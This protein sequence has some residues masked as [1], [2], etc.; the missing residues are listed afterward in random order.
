M[1]MRAVML[2]AAFVAD[3]PGAPRASAQSG[4]PSPDSY[5]NAAQDAGSWILPA[6]SY[7]GNRYLSETDITAANV[8]TLKKAWSAN[9]D[10]RGPLETSPIVWNGTMY[11]TSSHNDVY[12]L[13]AKT[14]AV[15]WHFPYKPH[16]IAFSANR[17]VALSDGKVY[18]ATLDGKL[19]ALDATTGKPVWNV[20]AAHD[21]DEHVL[22]HAARPVQEHADPRRVERRLGRHRVHQRIRRGDRQTAVGLEDDSGPGRARPHDVERRLVETRRRRDLERR[23]DRPGEQHAVRR[24]RKPAARLSRHDPQRHEPLHEL[25]GRARHQRHDAE[26]E[27][28]SPVHPARH[29]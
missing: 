7:S 28:V 13:D 8:G 23:R 24:R 10:A 14:G 3:P 9:V 4:W 27:M 15:K 11:V 16:V 18:E 20:V 17:G 26:A 6:H 1:R 5:A 2:V 12:A 21:V 29:A 22:H 19:I 25:D